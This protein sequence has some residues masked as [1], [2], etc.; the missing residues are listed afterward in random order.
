M[1]RD[2]CHV[3]NGNNQMAN[4]K[5]QLANITRQ[6]TNV[7]WPNSYE[8]WR[9]SNCKLQKKSIIKMT[10][11]TWRMVN[12]RK[13]K[14]THWHCQDKT[15]SIRKQEND[16]RNYFILRTMCRNIDQ[17]LWPYQ[18]CTGLNERYLCRWYCLIKKFGLSRIK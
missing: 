1:T 11:D 18:R 15:S 9:I 2:K 14:A 13:W 10:N 4:N 17:L 16:F 7:S 6:M 5:W 3:T 8:K 12:D